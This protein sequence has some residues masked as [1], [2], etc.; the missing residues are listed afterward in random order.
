MIV[1][2]SFVIDV[3]G[4]KGQPAIGFQYWR[5]PGPFASYLLPGAVGKFTGFWSVFINA[6][7]AYSGV[8]SVA[9]CAAETKNPIKAIPK[10]TKRVFYRV[11]GCYIVCVFFAGLVVPST[12]ETLVKGS[13]A[14]RSAFV[15]AAQLAGIKG[16]IAST[17]KSTWLIN[18][19]AAP[20]HKCY[21]NH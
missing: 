4:V 20:H 16:I 3:G 6:A 9:I 15:I 12:N 5:N 1:I 21:S 17:M 7:Y 18:V 11:F 19:S 10:A 13:G 2:M 14:S 8:E